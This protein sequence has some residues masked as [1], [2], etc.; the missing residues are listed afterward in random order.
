MVYR[1]TEAGMS[2]YAHEWSAAKDAG[3]RAA[4]QVTPVGFEGTGGIVTGVRVARVDDQKQPMQG[5]EHVIPADLVLLAVGQ[6]KQGSLALAFGLEVDR[7]RIVVGP[8]G[9]T[10]NPAVF[11]GGDGA[12]GGK[13]VVNAVAEGRDAALA[14]HAHLSAGRT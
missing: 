7:G 12:N 2:G 6:S 3:A 5:S 4:W 14:I 13:E 9:S 1:G 8:N 11:A 10:A